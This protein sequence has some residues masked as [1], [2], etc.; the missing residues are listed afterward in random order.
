MENEDGKKLA[1]IFGSHS[2]FWLSIL[3]VLAL[4]SGCSSFSPFSPPGASYSFEKEGEN[5]RVNISDTQEIKNLNASAEPI[6]LKDGTVVCCKISIKKAAT[7]SEGGGPL[8]ML[9]LIR[10]VA[11]LLRGAP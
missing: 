6:I 4:F 10:E 3:L 2:L 7:K 5:I 8:E 1:I 11:P 9:K